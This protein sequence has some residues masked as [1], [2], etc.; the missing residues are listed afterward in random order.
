MKSFGMRQ[1]G[2]AVRMGVVLSACFAIAAMTS[3]LLLAIHFGSLEHPAHHD[4]YDCPV[5][6]QL[7]VVPKGLVPDS[8]VGLVHEAL[9]YPADVPEYV[10][11]IR[12]SC[13]RSSQPRGPPGSSRRQTV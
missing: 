8:H 6:Q 2:T 1:F 5:C 13:L 12:H 9:V 4:C 3:G 7:L 11:C 10:E